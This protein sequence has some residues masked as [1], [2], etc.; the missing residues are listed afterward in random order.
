MSLPVGQKVSVTIAYYCEKANDTSYEYLIERYDQVDQNM[1]GNEEN[2]Y[3][4]PAQAGAS[5]PYLD[6]RFPQ[7]RTKKSTDAD[8]NQYELKNPSVIETVDGSPN[9]KYNQLFKYDHCDPVV[10]AADGSAV[11]KVY[12]N[13]VKFT[14][15]FYNRDTFTGTI[16]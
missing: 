2:P 13:R 16:N 8:F 14:Y 9:M 11:C 7:E 10:V 4:I 6:R 1:I 5:D 15:N 3:T 12:L